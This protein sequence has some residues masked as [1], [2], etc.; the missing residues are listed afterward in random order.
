MSGIGLDG[1]LGVGLVIGMI[2]FGS[3]LCGL[4]SRADVMCGF[5]S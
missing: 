4:L 2:V 5:G 3:E 1:V